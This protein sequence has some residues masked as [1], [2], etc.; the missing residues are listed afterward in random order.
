MDREQKN[1]ALA[2]K[3]SSKMEDMIPLLNSDVKRFT[4]RAKEIQHAELIK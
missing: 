1:S 4:K 2:E 3:E